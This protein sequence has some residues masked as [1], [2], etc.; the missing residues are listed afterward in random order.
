MGTPEALEVAESVPQVLPLQPEPPR[1]QRTLWLRREVVTLAVNFCVPPGTCTLAVAGETVT[2]CAVTDGAKQAAAIKSN[3]AA[4]KNRTKTPGLGDI[5]R[6]PPAN[7]AGGTKPS[8]RTAR[9]AGRT[10]V[11]V[12]AK[13]TRANRTQGQLV[14]QWQ[15]GQYANALRSRT[16]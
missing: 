8:E 6:L 4:R 7:G 14:R 5:R 2:V 3:K 13:R 10:R 9:W 11:I 12:A 1:D 16:L 15:E